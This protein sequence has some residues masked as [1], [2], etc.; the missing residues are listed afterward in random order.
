[1]ALMND[2][3]NLKTNSSA[4]A[5]ELRDFMSKMKGR[6]PQEVLGLVAGSSLFQATAQA[7]F[8]TVVLTAIFTVG[9]YMMA[10]NNPPPK[11]TAAATKAPEKEPAAKPETPAKTEN[12]TAAATPANTQASSNPA[13]T[14]GN[15]DVDKAAKAMGIGET[16]SAD[17]KKNPLDNLDKLLDD[18]K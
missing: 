9:P 2:L 16:K 8:W 17:P 4:S 18:A 1:M 13:P 10:K 7:T 11:D 14:S 15:S 12:A 5:D 3:Q 6:S